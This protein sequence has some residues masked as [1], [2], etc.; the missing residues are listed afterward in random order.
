M[1]PTTGANGDS[2]GLV[3][4][5]VTDKMIEQ[6]RSKAALLMVFDE[7]DEETAKEAKKLRLEIRRLRLRIKDEQ[8]ELIAPHKAFIDDINT[9]AKTIIPAMQE[10]EATLKEQEDIVFKAEERAV[11]A[12]LEKLKEIEDQ[13]A[14][15]KAAEVPAA[16]KAAEEAAAAT[17][18]EESTGFEG[19]DDGFGDTPAEPSQPEPQ[20]SERPR[21]DIDLL[22]DYMR[23][24]KEITQAPVLFSDVDCYSI[25][26]E[27][28]GN[29]NTL[30][31]R[32]E[33]RLI[34]YAALHDRD[35]KL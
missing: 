23:R 29:L 22:T 9:Q 20:P 21:D 13:Q 34:A 28:R 19:L 35:V 33:E 27:L 32:A 30:Y 5:S 17:V 16:E 3:E 1:S 31:A 7:T 11:A 15:E 2:G 12:K 8:N 24:V 18:A 25:I 4:L 26:A 6:Y 10:M 14:A